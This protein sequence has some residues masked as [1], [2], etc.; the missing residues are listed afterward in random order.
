ME[1]TMRRMKK[2][3]RTGTMEA[4]SDDTMSRSGPSR[5]NSR[6]TRKARSDRMVLTGTSTGPRATRDMTTTT[7]SKR[8]QPSLRKGRSQWA[9]RFTSS[10]AVKMRVKNMS[11]RSRLA[12]VGVREPSLLTMELTSCASAALTKKFCGAKV[13]EEACKKVLR[14]VLGGCLS[15][16]IRR[17]PLLPYISDV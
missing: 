10:S 1:E 8:F 12:P 16:G 14:E 6:T 17:H 3:L 7:E 11:R 2:A 5:P 13:H 9:K 4:V 15:L